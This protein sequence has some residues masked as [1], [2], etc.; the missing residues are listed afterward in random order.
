[1]KKE[2]F[3]SNTINKQRFIHLLSDRLQNNIACQTLHAD[4]D[5][6]LLIVMTA[7]ASAQNTT[8]VL[9]GDDTDLLML[10]IHHT[11]CDVHD[12]YLTAE[13]K[14]NVRKATRCWN[15]KATQDA[16]GPVICGTI[17]F[18][19]AILGCDTVSRIHGMGKGLALKKALDSPHFIQQANV[20]MNPKSTQAEVVLAGHNALVSLCNG[21]QGDTLNILR[22][23]RF[24]EKVAISTVAVQPKVLPPTCAAAHYHSLRVFYQVHEW[25]PEEGVEFEPCDWGWRVVDSK[26]LPIMMDRDAAPKVLLEMIRCGCKSGCSSKMCSC[27]KHGLQCSTACGACKGTG[28]TNSGDMQ[29]DSSDDEDRD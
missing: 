2:E 8:T 23:R 17:L 22:H 24:C 14:A 29:E 27:R 11:T 10:L 4:G 21:K 20:F 16:L 19:H 7:L 18:I 9:I 1:M 12:V 28:C 5:A 15:I 25:K 6:D 13:P 26:M 3:L